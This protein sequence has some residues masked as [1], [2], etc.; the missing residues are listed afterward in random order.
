MARKRRAVPVPWRR[1][2]RQYARYT[3]PRCNVAYCSLACYKQHS[4]SCTSQFQR[5]HATGELQGVRTDDSDKKAILEI[6]RRVAEQRQEDEEA[7]RPLLEAVMQGL[8][9]DA[10]LVRVTSSLPFMDFSFVSPFHGSTFRGTPCQRQ[11]P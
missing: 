1:C 4:D 3:C 11:C 9:L 6:L 10:V 8:S 5:E 2:A 7:Q